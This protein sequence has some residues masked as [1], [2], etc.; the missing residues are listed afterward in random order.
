MNIS[1]ILDI[2]SHLVSICQVDLFTSDRGLHRYLATILV[3]PWGGM[4]LWVTLM[5]YPFITEEFSSRA[6]LCSRG[7]G[8]KT[9]AS[10]SLFISPGA[11]S[12]QAFAPRLL[13][14][15]SMG[16]K[17]QTV[18]SYGSGRPQ[19]PHLA[20]CFSLLTSG[21]LSSAACSMWHNH[22]RETQ[23]VNTQFAASLEAAEGRYP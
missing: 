20:H 13:S 12:G 3:S 21:N 23:Q 16:T 7:T 17:R 22:T 8:S 1:S 18:P 5:S 2:S 9:P 4:G 14:S 19:K 6:S 10:M 11:Q 15:N